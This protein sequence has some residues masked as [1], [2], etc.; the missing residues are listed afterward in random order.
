MMSIKQ[1]P[2]RRTN[3]PF[4]FTSLLFSLLLFASPALA[5]SPIVDNSTGADAS[6]P[7][8]ATLNGDLTAGTTA[9]IQ[10][11]WG[12]SDG[13]TD[14]GSWDSVID[15]GV[16]SEGTFSNNVAGL[17][18]GVRYFY[19]CYAT[20]IASGAWSGSTAIFVTTEPPG[21]VGG[22]LSIL[23]VTANSGTNPATGNPWQP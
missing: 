7:T 8:N 2:A 22:Q 23:D 19:R 18:Y 5:Q 12:E 4:V 3:I 16:L 13:G 10:I 15:L 21:G 11:Y 9:T 20:N 1:S 14:K 17:Y 6:S